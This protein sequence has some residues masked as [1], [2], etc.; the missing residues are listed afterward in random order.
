MWDSMDDGQMDMFLGEVLLELDKA[1]LHNASVWYLLSHHEET[2]G[3]LPPPSPKATP[4][5]RRHATSSTPSSE[6]TPSLPVKSRVRGY[7][8]RQDSLGNVCK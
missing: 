8:K 7:V 4:R 3:P 5:V 6:S 2:S 1:D